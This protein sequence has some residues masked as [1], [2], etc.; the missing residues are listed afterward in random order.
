[1]RLGVASAAGAS[2]RWVRLCTPSSA[3]SG[4]DGG[5][6]DRALRG[7]RDRVGDVT[8]GHRFLSD[9]KPI[10][11][12]RLEDYV[13]KLE[14]AHVILDADRRR[15]IILNDARNLAFAQGCELIEDEGL[16]EEVAGLV[17]W[18]TVLMGSFD[19]DFLQIPAEV[20]RATI[21]RT[22]NA[23]CCGTARARSPT[24]SC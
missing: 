17:E 12:R 19:A 18:P 9:G 24:A 22:R 2:L 14:A 4:R 3:P 1:M 20:I 7:G 8:F 16:L 23:S 13:A 11:V 15:Q 5:A 10:R 6:G 21:R